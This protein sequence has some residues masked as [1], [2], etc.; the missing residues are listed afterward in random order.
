MRIVI[1]L[2]IN[3]FPNF[4][5]CGGGGW[6]NKRVD[7]EP[8]V[9]EKN[10]E[11][12]VSTDIK[13]AAADSSDCKHLIEWNIME[14]VNFKY[15]HS[16]YDHSSGMSSI[17]FDLPDNVADSMVQW[18]NEAAKKLT[19]KDSPDTM[20][21]QTRGISLPSSTKL[22]M[23]GKLSITPACKIMNIA[24]IVNDFWGK[25]TGLSWL[26]N[27]PKICVS[28][29]EFISIQD[30]PPNHNSKKKPHMIWSVLN[31]PNNPDI[32]KR[33]IEIIYRNPGKPVRKYIH[34]FI[35]V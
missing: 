8:A 19:Q 25:S 9:S 30:S 3:F 15:A 27:F 29:F 28:D 13:K 34:D 26:A 18:G 11:L 22:E 31:C 10:T 23:F 21:F 35:G 7:E 1:V 32:E 4:F 33:F 2:I 5:G 17:K 20:V 12:I 6:N 16:V 24:F 14:D